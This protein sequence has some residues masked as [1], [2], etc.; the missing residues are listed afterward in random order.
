MSRRTRVF[1]YPRGWATH[2]P[3]WTTICTFHVRNQLAFRQPGH[4]KSRV[5]VMEH[6]QIRRASCC[7]LGAADSQ[8]SSR[9]PGIFPRRISTISFSTEVLP[10]NP[11]R[12]ANGNVCRSSREIQLRP[13]LCAFATVARQET[14]R[15]ME[16]PNPGAIETM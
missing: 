13:P 10:I 5:S 1:Y 14:L 7:G 16:L 11:S 6:C 15:L 2:A 12:Y 4:G 3:D 8:G 9:C